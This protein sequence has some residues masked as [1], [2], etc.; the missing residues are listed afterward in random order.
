MTGRLELV[1]HKLCPYVQRVAIALAEKGAP[2]ERIYIDLADKP[3]W[4]VAMSPLAKVPLLKVDGAV[5][6]ESAAICDY[7]DDVIAPR[8]HPAAPLARARHRAWIEFASS[9]LAAIGA[10]YG[11]ADA[12]AFDQRR[13]DLK[14]RFATVEAVLGDGPW[15]GGEHFS[16][17]DAAFAPALRYFS[18]FDAIGDFGIFDATPKLD[19]WRVRLALRPSVI[20]AVT[21]DY[22]ALLLAF[23][24]A[25]RSHLAALQAAAAATG[26]MA[27]RR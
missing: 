11:A 18:V 9:V 4:F 14:A 2:F 6:F 26:P 5:L 3:D 24:R 12:A 27:A 10:F 20:A 21:P 8:L 16:L 15:F 7:L 13:L 22:P 17:V 19:A 23:V 1:S 25:R